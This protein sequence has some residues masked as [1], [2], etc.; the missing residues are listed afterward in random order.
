MM[1]ASNVELVVEEMTEEHDDDDDDDDDVRLDV[2]GA[3]G[4]WKSNSDG[5]FLTSRWS[6]DVSGVDNL[7]CG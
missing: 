4:N 6:A 2:A 1:P 5:T 7:G 3:A